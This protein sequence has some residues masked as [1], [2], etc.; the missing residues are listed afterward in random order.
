MAGNTLE[1]DA[2]K[3]VAVADVV[4]YGDKL[5][6]PDGMKYPVAIDLIHRRMK[7]EEETVELSETFNA[8][9]WDGAHAF[10]QVLINKF[11]WAPS[12]TKPGGFFT[13]PQP[14]QLISV[15]VA[16]G[17]MKSVP[18]GLF[19]LPTV[20]GS[21][22]CTTN[23][24]DGGIRFALEATVKRKDESTIKQLFAD[25]REY[26]KQHSIYRGKAIKLRFRDDNGKTLKMPEPKF[27][28]TALIDPSELI[29]SKEI[30]SSIET[31]L[32]TP[33]RR[34]A[35]CIANNIPVKRG[36]LL[37]GD[38]GT[39]KTM[40]A[41]IAA[42]YAVEEGLTYITVLRADELAD[43][44]NFARLYGEPACVLFCED[45]DRTMSGERTVQ[46]DDILNILDGVDSKKLNLITVLT[47][48]HLDNINAAM[49][50]PG[51][52]DAIIE[53]L[54]PDAEAVNRLIRKVAGNALDATTD[55]TAACEKLANNVPAV[56]TEVVKRAK[57]SQLSR[58]AP[59]T[60]VEKLTGEALDDAAYT[61][62]RQN[63]LLR[64]ASAP[65]PGRPSLDE[66]FSAVVR[67]S[68]NGDQAVDGSPQKLKAEVA[69]SNGL[70]GEIV[71]K[72]N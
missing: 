67:K 46:I 71:G 57:L 30:E 7:F 21:V 10:E 1:R 23:V 56:I 54:A 11:G 65:K 24:I 8:F 59:G 45:I 31:N 2:Q 12:E 51:R 64:R 39:G 16:P 43:A 25:L 49:L 41:R 28:D 22:E 6:I 17:V 40:G 14:P 50:R 63:E 55:I 33:I 44:I 20:N 13:P 38:Y 48:N 5:V 70:T 47:T 60:L 58:Q 52:L 36:V 9:P 27:I 53:V 34:V 3:E 69:L 15:E 72:I 4:R 19:S 29:Y 42:K 26:L 18:W 61:M 66:A 68:V 62:T 35:D 32:F 37:G